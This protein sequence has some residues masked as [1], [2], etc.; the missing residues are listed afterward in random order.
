MSLDSIRGLIN[1][2]MMCKAQGE[3][4]D[5]NCL[6]ALLQND[7]LHYF[8]SSCKPVELNPE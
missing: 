8:C 5:L 1:R 7:T 3:V 2:K 6:F 4:Q